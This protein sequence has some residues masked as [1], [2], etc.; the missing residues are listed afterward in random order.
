MQYYTLLTSDEIGEFAEE[1]AARPEGREAQRR[2]AA[3]VTR[4]THGEPGLQKALTATNVLFGGDLSD[5]SA[6]DLLDVFQDVPSSSLPRE[7]LEGHGIGL[8]ELAVMTGLASSRG[9]ARRLIRGGGIAVGNRRV[10]DD[11]HSVRLEH[12]VDGKVIV[13]RRGAREFRLVRLHD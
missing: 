6:D 12:S 13:I 1:V 10:S 8:Q 7:R 9:E 3:E 2:L 4:M 11:R 5:L